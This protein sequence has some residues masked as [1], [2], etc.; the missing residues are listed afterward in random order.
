MAW[1]TQPI[2]RMPSRNS[3]RILMYHRFSAR[4][5]PRRLSADMFERHVRFISRYFEPCH[6]ST[7]ARAVASGK[8]L[9]A[10]VVA[11][12]VDDGYT[13][14]VETA[15]P[16]LQRYGVPATLYVVTGCS[17]QP[18]WLWFDALRFCIGHAREQRVRLPLADRDLA[19]DMRTAEGR[20]RAWHQIGDLCLALPST[21]RRDVLTA[22]QG[23][24]GV[25]LPLA[26]SEDDGRTVDWKQLRALDPDLIELGCHSATHPNLPLCT[27]VELQ[28]EIVESRQEIERETGRCP[29]TFSYPNGQRG[30]YD[31]RVMRMIRE[32]GYD[33]AVVAHEGFAEGAA[34]P[35]ALPRFALPPHY[36]RFR[37]TVNGYAGR[38]QGLRSRRFWPRTEPMLSRSWT[39]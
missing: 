30:D 12:T 16:I 23:A 9:P 20:E 5:T 22:V 19:L 32:A 37:L 39:F 2:A 33:G 4:Q 11:I 8:R 38:R 29:A 7:I 35:F 15:Y 36:W 14:F 17:A 21:A 10:N 13:D 27:D 25:R 34:N 31:G 3:A 18:S 24:F 28:A 6:V 26:P 1:L